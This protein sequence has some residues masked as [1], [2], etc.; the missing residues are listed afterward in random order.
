M[1]S[2]IEETS[3]ELLAREER[4]AELQHRLLKLTAD[5]ERIETAINDAISKWKK[6][7]DSEEQLKSL[8]KQLQ[9]ARNTQTS[10]PPQFAVTKNSQQL[11]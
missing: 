5:K 8:Y 1:A 7:D 11:L 9:Q 2:L 4:L 10:E 6:R 3:E